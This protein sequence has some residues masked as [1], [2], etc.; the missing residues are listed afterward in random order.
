MFEICINHLPPYAIFFTKIFIIDL[1]LQKKSDMNKEKLCGLDIEEIFSLIEPHGYAHH[2]AVSIAN[3]IYKKRV[4]EI[5]MLGKI[6]G[7]LRD[8]LMELSD[9]GT[10]RPVCS[11]SSDDGAVKYLFRNEIGLEYETVYL[12]DGKRRTV[13]ISTQS[14]CRMGCSF[15]A[16][17]RYGFRGNLT[18]GDIVNQIVSL[19]DAGDITH[20]VF[21]G[22]GEPMDNLDNVLRACRIITSEWGLALSQRN[23]T[24]S[25]V[26]IKAGVERFLKESGCNLTLSLHSPFA[27]ERRRLIPAEKAN[28]VSDIITLMKDFPLLKKRRFSLAYVMIKDLNDTD[29]HLEALMNLTLGSSIR[30][31][32]L[33]YHSSGEDVLISSS[34]ERMQYFKHNLVVSGVSASVRKSR[35]DDISASCGLLAAGRSKGHEG[36]N[37]R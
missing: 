28:P 20:V 13:C 29:S 4:T 3:G 37:Y 23:V 9:T 14:G 35:G 19:P 2:H 17:G 31:N 24:V 6:P 26:G 8:L 22:M 30:V 32:L 15:C 27:E 34:S 11:E 18:A 1:L 36:K 12:P 7:K 21:M 16:T 10:F 25:T 5:S 33:P